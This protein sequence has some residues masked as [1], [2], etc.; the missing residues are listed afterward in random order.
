MSVA[1]NR[2]NELTQL[3][4]AVTALND[5]RAKLESLQQQRSA[6]IAV[7]GMSCRFPGGANSTSEYW[8]LLKSGK[9]AISELPARQFTEQ[10]KRKLEELGIA[11]AKWGG[12]LDEVDQFD[13]AF[14][15]IAPREAVAMDPQQR[16]LLEVAWEALEDAG[17]PIPKLA[18]S[19]TGVFVGVHSHSSDYYLLQ[20]DSFSEEDVYVGTGTAH[21]VIA[22]RLSYLFDWRGPSMAIDTACSSSLV[23]VHLAVQSL[24]TGESDL[25][26]AAG[27]NLMLS[28]DFTVHAARM[29]MLALDGRCKTFDDSANGF[30]RGEGCGVVVLKRL[31]EAMKDG[32]PI[33]AIIRGTAVNQDGRSNGLTAPN[34]LSQQDVIRTAL[35]NAGIKPSQIGY[36]ETHGTGTVLGDPIEADSLSQVLGEGRAI[37]QK[38]LLGSAKANIGHLEG[39]AGIASFIKAVLILKNQAIPPQI[40]FK[41]LN[42]HIVLGKEFEI[43]TALLAWPAGAQSRCAGISSFGWSGTNAHVV[44]EEARTETLRAKESSNPEQHLLVLSGHT[45]EA[46]AAMVRA[47]VDFLPAQSGT[48]LSDICYTA[49]ARRMH[50]EY[51]LAVLGTSCRE[52]AE[53]LERYLQGDQDAAIWTGRVAEHSDQSKRDIVDRKI[54]AETASREKILQSLATDFVAGRDIEWPKPAESRHVALPSYPWQRSRY[55]VEVRHEATISGLLG[56]AQVAIPHPVSNSAPSDWFYQLN[57]IEKPVPLSSGLGAREDL[58]ALAR[59][60]CACALEKL[61]FR[62]EIGALFDETETIRL[63]NVHEKH[64]RLLARL[65]AILH[66][67]GYLTHE[68][69]RWKI[70]GRPEVAKL[71]SAADIAA[72]HPEHKNEFGLLMRCGERLADVL[73]DGCDPL[74]LLFP[75]GEM[76]PSAS[77]FY[78]ESTSLRFYNQVLADLLSRVEARHAGRPLRILEVGAGTGATTTCI[79]ERMLN[80]EFDYVFTDVS[81]SLLNES[82]A[83]L[84]DYG[85]IRYELLDIESDPAKQG[86]A[87]N[88]FDF[89]VC[90]NVLHATSDLSNTLTH[91]RKLLTN[92]GLLLLIEATAPRAWMDLT[93]GLTEGWWRFTDTHLRPTHPLLNADRWTEVLHKS[94]FSQLEVV[95]ASYS[96]GTDLEEAIFVAR[97]GDVRQH[98]LPR[99]RWLILADSLGLGT[100]VAE[101]LRARQHDCLLVPAGREQE[102]GIDPDDANSYARLFT[103]SVFDGVLHLWNLANPASRKIGLMDI[104]QSHTL[105]FGSVM[106]LLHGMA[107]SEA[108]LW[109]VTRNAQHVDGSALPLSVV[110][111]PVWGLGRSLA[112]E[113]PDVWGGLID[114]EKGD[115]EECADHI[116]RE[117]CEP[118]GEDQIVLRGSRRFAARLMSQPEPPMQFMKIRPNASYLLTGGLGGLGRKLAKWLAAQGARYLVLIGRSDLPN[119]STWDHL[120]ESDPHFK[121]IAAIREAEGRGA[122]VRVEQVDVGDAAAMGALFDRLRAECPPL[123]GVIHAATAFEF[124]SMEE[125]NELAFRAMFRAKISGAWILHE[126]TQALE[127]DFFVLFSSASSQLGVKYGTHYAAANQ[128]LDG[129]AHF[130]RQANLPAVSINWGEWDEMRI[131]TD[132]QLAFFERSGLRP[133]ES[134][135]AIDA[136]SRLVAAGVVQQTVA[137]IDIPLLKSAFQVSGRKPFLESLR[138]RVSNEKKVAGPASSVRELLAAVPLQDRREVIANRVESEVARIMGIVSPSRI[139]PQRG[140]FEMGMDSLMSV[141]LRTRLEIAFERSLSATTIFN[142]PSVAALTD[143]F[144]EDLLQV[145]ASENSVGSSVDSNGDSKLDGIEHLSDEEARAEL[146]KELNSFHLEFDG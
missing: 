61:G 45:P 118:D 98:V 67:S 37:G 115:L 130:R 97:P 85:S 72:S 21:N 65:F 117:I 11:E 9:D 143:L 111:A 121:T 58:E 31:S 76:I 87:P 90:A 49:S 33:L 99:Q 124:R 2:P 103:G 6:P 112:L 68:G 57:W 51:R 48:N 70:L 30:V 83:R 135:R 66:E 128:F 43:P 73:R 44:L 60:Y 107:G 42:P 119:R 94:G 139:D 4:Q 34:G 123:A 92:D 3:K 136:M 138:E 100:R 114:I 27:V 23:A 109:V 131:L 108:K 113:R 20:K 25:C 41:R 55:W 26:L 89:V 91:I 125:M 12:F 146:V 53:R 29:S 10:M 40:H 39:A 17:L 88:S 102:N 129:L 79:L 140:L 13:P 35:K 28:L 47:Y 142:H 64:T 86:F 24:R 84:R 80:R 5:M 74:E 22:G 46:L 38:C 127:L 82:A 144:A 104:E 133:M 95:G 78:R 106:H 110:H 134:E 116:V 81:R 63:L 18:G 122:V 96:R 120:S 56:G 137:N 69:G 145:A 36:L 75:D 8:S 19:R 126:L 141:Q 16:L 54:P 93:F 101:R 105:G 15:G 1:K 50:Q 62:F 71:A 77:A 132:E 59:E 32:D 52:M 14:F 7:V